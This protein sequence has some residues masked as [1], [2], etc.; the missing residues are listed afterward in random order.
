MALSADRRNEIAYLV[1][2]RKLA[3]EDVQLNLNS[4]KRRL[5]V[6]V[7]EID[8]SME[9]LL[10]LAEYLYRDLVEDMFCDELARES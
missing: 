4:L 7:N 9:E 6:L 2:K 1:L 10:G 8:V 5:G 3:R